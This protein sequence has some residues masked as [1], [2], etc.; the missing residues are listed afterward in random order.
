MDL[1]NNSFWFRV[2]LTVE[3]E[4]LNTKKNQNKSQNDDKIARL[5]FGVF[6]LSGLSGFCFLQQFNLG[7]LFA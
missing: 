5:R 3:L 7:S 1:F 2:K 4:R 6:Q